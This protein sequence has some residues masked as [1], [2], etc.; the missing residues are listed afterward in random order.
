MNQNHHIRDLESFRQTAFAFRLPRILLTALDLDVF[1]VMGTRSWT[2]E[3]LAKELGASQRGVEILCRNL[4]SA[5]LLTK[6]DSRYQSGK[7]GQTILNAKSPQYRGAY[8]DLMRRQWHDWSHL[9]E[10]VK[11]GRPVDDEEP[12]DPEYRRSFTWAMHYRSLD[13]AK[14]VAQQL[15]LKNARTLLDVGGGPGTYALAFLKRNPHLQATVLDRPA[16]L[17]VAKEIAAPVKEGKRISYLPFDFMKQ[18]VQG[19]Y[20]VIWLS[21]VVHIYSAE[22]NKALFRK[23]ASALSSGGRFL[24]QD[25]LLLDKQRLY[26]SETNLFAV[27]M[28]LFTEIGNTYSAREVQEWL[29]VSGLVKPRCVHLRKGT[30]DWEGTLVEASR[31]ST[32]AAR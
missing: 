5:G 1:T 13:A 17:E 3:A 23:L 7:L 32:R 16:A 18:A 6:R 31:P 30:G 12:E 15:N 20:D 27:T 9:T 14:Q 10:S 28:L 2:I 8:L 26:P 22:E 4:A 24:I 21:N 11:S 29:R 19:A 25:T